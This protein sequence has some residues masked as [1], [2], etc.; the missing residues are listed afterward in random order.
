VILS[1]GT[2]IG[3]YEIISAVGAGGM[4]EVYRARDTKLGRD[5]ALKILPELFAAD[6]DRLARFEREA[7][8]LASLNHPHI[9]QIYGVEESGAVRALAMEFVDGDDL[10]RRIAQGPIAIE[11]ALPI[12]RQIAQALEAAHEAGIVHRDL[13]PANIKVRPDGTV[14]VLDFG[15]ARALEPVG[16][17]AS[18]PSNSPTIT[19]ATR[20]G[21]ILG[22][23]AYMAPEQAKGKPVDKR[24]DI[25]SFGAVLF[26]ILT[27]ERAFDGAD[28]SEI[29][30]AVLRQE[31][32]WA[33]LPPAT[34]RPIRRLLERCLRRDLSQRLR[35]IGDARVEIDEALE[36]PGESTSV[37]ASRS[38]WARPVTFVLALATV[39]IAAAVLS[40]VLV[41]TL[42]PPAARPVTRFS[43]TLSAGERF[44]TVG[45]DL[46]VTPDGSAI[47]Y[48]TSQGIYLRS[49]S[50]L[51]TRQIPN[52]G[53]I[54][55][56]LSPTFS[57]DGQSLAFWTTRDQTLRTVPVSG[58]TPLV[59]GQVPAD[60]SGFF[61]G[62]VWTPLGILLGVKGRVGVFPPGGGSPQTFTVPAGEVPYFARMLPGNEYLIYTAV[63]R[64][65]TTRVSDGRIVAQS[66]RTGTRK[67]LIDAG[68][69]ARYLTSGHLIY[70]RGGVLFAVRFDPRRVEM[71]GQP[72]AVVEGVRRAGLSTLTAQYGV[73]DTGTLVYVPGP[74]DIAS[75]PLDLVL[76]DRSGEIQPLKIPAGTYEAP[77]AS[78]DGKYVAFSTDDGKEANVWVYDLS[79]ASSARRLT[80]GGRSRFPVW[81][82]DGRQI[83]FQSD[84]EGD[85]AIFWQRADGG[86]LAE[87]LTKP[88]PGEIHTPESF[89]PKGDV[90]LF[91]AA[92]GDV[93]KLWALSLRSKTATPFGGVESIDPIGAVFS[94]DGRWVAYGIV[95]AGRS[96]ST[97]FVQPFPPTGATYQISRDDDGHH[98]VWSPDGH[99]LTYVPGPNRLVA[100]LVTTRPTFTISTPTPLPPAGIMGPPRVLRNHDIMPDG[101]RFIGLM[102]A[103]E[104]RPGSRTPAQLHVVL[105]WF[106]ELRQRV[107]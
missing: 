106:E 36:Q 2:R 39:A 54:E 35:D 80:F 23:A 11:E 24:A 102:P 98:P 72:V 45:R 40:G 70:A 67:I 84:R 79:G 6:P 78:P 21:I 49:L 83:A 73:S 3:A 18:D 60:D 94:P 81:T 71:L 30:A 59:I 65:G 37:E 66:V 89:S 15:L 104:G 107:P 63:T 41:R 5:V 100:V 22:T 90:L 34:P 16:S 48:A 68:S 13:K 105:N 1:S 32:A 26:E 31:I 57:P 55:G 96:L 61:G 14:K 12:A 99:R 97:V 64:E 62:I 43:I 20:A 58:G 52:T 27:G 88:A 38:W 101:A 25:W 85:S 76:F 75:A 77:R 87:R 42:V 33:K 28:S 9:A 44:R 10:A 7:R 74:A 103:G 56:V 53:G 4:G 50:S 86:G 91:T 17:G 95:R 69:D 29:L 8:M 93:S 92:K 82:P 46:D 51:E 19:A 47:V